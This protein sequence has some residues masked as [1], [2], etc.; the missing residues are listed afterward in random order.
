MQG[1]VD[2]PDENN[3][4][5]SH[6]QATVRVS[7]HPFR[8]IVTTLNRVSV[9]FIHWQPILNKLSRSDSSEPEARQPIKI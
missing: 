2:V 1:L 5:G 3:H 4:L 6:I 7:S 9:D 8:C